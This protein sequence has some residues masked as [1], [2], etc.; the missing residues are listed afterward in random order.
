MYRWL[1]CALLASG[2]LP[3]PG[4]CDE[5]AALELVY[6]EEGTPAFAGQAILQTSC[7]NGGFC[8][9][10]PSI[11]PGDRFGAP[12]DLGFDLRVASTSGDTQALETERLR[13]HLTRAL[14]MRREL[15]AQ[16][17][18]GQMPPEGDAG[19]TYRCQI[20]PSTCGSGGEDL[21]YDRF[22]DDGVTFTPLPTLLDQDPARRDEAEEIVRNWL[23]CR[24]PVVERTV[25]RTDRGPNLVGFTVAACERSCVD[26]RWPEI[27]GRIIEPTCATSRCHDDS[28]PASGLDMLTGGADGMHA[29]L[30]AGGQ[31][32]DGAQCGPTGLTLIVASMPDASLLLQKVEAATGDDVC[33]SRMPLQGNPLS[34]QRQCVLRA[35]IECGA[36]PEADGGA[37]AACLDAARED[38]NVDPTAASGCAS[39]APC[40]NRATL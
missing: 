4:P 9:A 1:S 35:W 24:T 2:C 19:A 22:A 10:E 33:G 18:A 8:H 29:R 5:T 37:C 26:V 34:P 38:C 11:P 14:G 31:R 36:C 20:L 32:A 6:T 17:Q 7:G 23:S 40:V 27:Y 15:L 21:A 13:N 39:T 3:S 12:V 25:D 30:V 16:I 28:D